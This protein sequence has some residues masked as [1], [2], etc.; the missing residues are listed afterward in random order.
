MT[1]SD[2][3]L[4]LR[5]LWT[6][7]QMLPPPPLPNPKP[8]RL[9]PSDYA[10]EWPKYQKKANPDAH[11]CLRPPELKGLPLEIL[12][13]AFITFKK[14]LSEPFP[15]EDISTESIVIN[16]GRAADSLCNVMG[17]DYATELLRG[18][19]FKTALN[20]I[21]PSQGWKSEYMCARPLVTKT[22]ASLDGVYI[23]RSKPTPRIRLI[24]Q[25]KPDK[26]YTSQPW[27]QVVHDY[28]WLIL[29]SED[30][31]PLHQSNGAATLLMVVQGKDN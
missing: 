21:F 14:C 9:P 22:H 7:H 2:F 20:D 11:L 3:I 10:K 28:R 23:D 27:V 6:A 16:A 31:E 24:R 1:Y 17:R 18:T 30:E 13:P 8:P 29:R 25:D 19:A 5:R 15:P 26:G 4:G 12:H